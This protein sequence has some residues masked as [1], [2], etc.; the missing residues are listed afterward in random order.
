MKTNKTISVIAAT[1]ILERETKGAVR[2]QEVDD[3][4]QPIEMTAAKIGTLYIRKTAFEVG[5]NV[6]K[7]LIVTVEP[8]QG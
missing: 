6:P 8:R 2:Y 1:F 5:G 7:R 3:K 4:D